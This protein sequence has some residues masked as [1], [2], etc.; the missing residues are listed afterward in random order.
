MGRS[1]ILCAYHDPLQIIDLRK[2]ATG[3]VT[4]EA[5][6]NKIRNSLRYRKLKSYTSKSRY[7]EQEEESTAPML[8]FQRILRKGDDKSPSLCPHHWDFSDPWALRKEYPI[9]LN[10]GLS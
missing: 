3:A 10:T 7:L 8:I 5:F 2:G 6:L 4:P 1:F 9:Y